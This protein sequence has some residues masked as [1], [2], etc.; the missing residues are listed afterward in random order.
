[1]NELRRLVLA[2]LLKMRRALALRVSIG[3]PLA[4]LSLQTVIASQ[5]SAV[6]SA[7]E[8]PFVSFA[9]NAL[10][11]WTLLVLPLHGA[12]LTALVAAIDHQDDHWKQLLAL[13]VSV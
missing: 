4:V 9:Q 1:M 13:P 7:G 5:R 10:M 11:L 6:R 8:N 3:V 12:L 2:E